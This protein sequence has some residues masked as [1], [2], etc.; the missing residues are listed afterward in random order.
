[1]SV[2]KTLRLVGAVIAG[3]LIVVVLSTATDAALHASGVYPPESEGFWDPGLITL[4]LAYRCAFTVLAGFV[5]AL[6]APAPK[7]RAVWILAVLGLAGG[8]AGLIGTWN[9]NLGPH[10]Y[11]IAL[12]ASAIPTVW[13]GGALQQRLSPRPQGA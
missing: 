9:L 10:W 4:A 11:P 8:L 13:L 12:A 7:M 5:C 3:F 6:L 1:M 2:P